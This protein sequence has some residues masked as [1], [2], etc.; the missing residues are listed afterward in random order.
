[1]NSKHKEILKIS[2]QNIK[3][4]FIW[5]SIGSTLN[6]FSSLFFLI[7]VT[8]VNGVNDAGIFTFGFSIAVLLSYIGMYHGRVFQVADTKKCKD[9]D[10]IIVKILTCIIMLIIAYCFVFIRDY[11]FDKTVVIILLC[12]F[13]ALEAFF[14][15]YYAIFQRNGELYKVGKSQTIKSILGIFIFLLVDLLTRNISYSIIALILINTC[16]YIFYDIPAKNKYKEDTQFNYSNIKYII[17]NGVLTF[18]IT[19]FTMYLSNAA[20]YVMDFMLTDNYQAIYG[21]I[22]M[23][24]T[25]IVLFAQYMIQPY[26]INIKNNFQIHKYNDIKKIMLKITKYTSIFGIFAIVSGYLLGTQVLELIYGIDIHKYR[27]DFVII[28][29]GAVLYGMNIIYSNILMAMN[30]NKQQA[31]IFGFSTLIVTFFSYTFINTYGFFG[32][33]LAYT[34]SMIPLY[35]MLRLTISGFLKGGNADEYK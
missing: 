33:S 1:M 6:A 18:L 19:F 17:K 28:L 22:I 16:I 31:I 13:K 30:K 8:R 34:L 5:N 11:Q 15:V 12:F 14:D 25:I 35:F 24:A 29:I 26:V 10:F 23:P 9:L 27:I 20:K 4:N 32:A 21:I 2:N 3:K 7:I